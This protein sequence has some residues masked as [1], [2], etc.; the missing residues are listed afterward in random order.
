M[1]V[2]DILGFLRQAMRLKLIPRLG[3][4]LR[5]I[6]APESVAE[7]IYGV[8]LLSLVLVDEIKE[9]I[10]KTRLLG[11]ALIHD[12]AECVLGDLPAPALGYLPPEVKKMAEARAVRNLVST[13]S[14]PEEWLGY[15]QEYEESQTTASRLVRDAD[16]LDMLLQALTYEEAGHRGL[17]EFWQQAKTYSWAFSASQRLY[18]TLIAERAR[19]K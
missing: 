18:N 7:H 3:W 14:H 19:M 10:D 17:G 16:R 6:P 8:M 15:L 5:G 4:A 9:E 1:A 11:I 12:L 2:E 13:L